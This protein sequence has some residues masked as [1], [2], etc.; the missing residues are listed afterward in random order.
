MDPAV[1]DLPPEVRP[2]QASSRLARLTARLDRWTSALEAP[3]ARWVRDPRYNPFYHSGT[4]ALW[5]LFLLAVTG[6]YLALFYHFGFQ[7]TYDSV[8]MIHRNIV[9]RVMRSVHR[10]ASDFFV[11][12][13]LLHAW[14]MWIQNRLRG[15]R[16]LAWVTGVAL[17]LAAL[18]TGVTGYWMLADDRAQWLHQGLVQGWMRSAWGQAWIVQWLIP[19]PDNSGWVYLVVLF[20]LHIGL[21]ALMGLFYWWHILR[22]NERRWFPPRYWLLALTGVWLLLGIV[23]P[24]E[25]RPVWDFAHWPEQ[26]PLDLWY[27]ALLPPWLQWGGWAAWGLAGLTFL[28]WA[29]WPWLWRTPQAEPVRL[30]QDACIGCT[31]C[32]RDCP[33][34][35]LEMIPRPGE[36]P[37]LIAQLHPDLCVGCGICVGS[38]PTDALTLD[39]PTLDELRERVRRAAQPEDGVAPRVT[40]VCHR[41]VLAHPELLAGPLS[42]E[43]PQGPRPVHVVAVPCVGDLHPDTVA[44]AWQSGAAEVQVIGC[45]PDDC[46]NRWGNTWLEGR[47]TRTRKP[48]LRVK[49]KHAPRR[50]DWVAP[51]DLAA[52]LRAPLTAP[53]GPP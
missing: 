27:L 34:R 19:R 49:W 18:L 29:A 24:V 16:V 51:A 31:L 9:G 37:K 50:Q 36:G 47:L 48:W 15:P 53:P 44:L 3:L 23:W 46:V 8:A 10:Y 26:V 22:L 33:Y 28:V 6:L 20:F 32:A 25:L 17:M 41:H 38:C 13:A 2:P 45:P 14:R 7:A 43:G 40:F 12:F 39:N 1:S 30:D 52:A 21:S 42:V 5:A 11:L 4:L 35:A